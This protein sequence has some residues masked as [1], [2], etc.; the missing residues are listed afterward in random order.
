MDNLET[1][2]ANE[3]FNAIANIAYAELEAEEKGLPI[4]EKKK[5]DEAVEPATQTTE[6]SSEPSTEPG[7]Q[8]AQPDKP[9][10]EAPTEEAPVADVAPTEAEITDYAV[11]HSMTPAEA[12]ADIEATKA[13]LKNYKSPEEIARALRST[14][15]AY[16]KLKSEGTKKQ[17]QVFA[18]MS[19]EQFVQQANEHFTKEQ[20]KH[21][22]KY[23]Q[24]FPKQSELM[25]DE[26]IIENIVYR[27]L[28]EYKNWAKEKVGEVQ[29]TAEKRREEIL[30][31]IPAD[32]RKWLPGV[33]GILDATDSRTI[34]DEG[35]DVEDL[36]RHARGEKAGYQA[37]IKEAEERGY[38]RGL[39]APKILGIKGID[40]KTTVNTKTTTG[41]NSAQQARAVQMFPD[42]SPEEAH[43][44]FKEVYEEDLKTNPNFVS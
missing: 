27:A 1:A 6:E 39:E 41:L 16:D 38:K 14:Q 32:D 22:E 2:V 30:A 17:P 43:K 24:M 7:T 40:G 10:E 37:A 21:V 3:D 34:L 19:D 11:K 4:P 26:A 20:E 9:A 31:N 42:L 18:P 35:F 28:G 13:V 23:R 5:D 36:L 29:K 33:K 44:S 8:E 25:T 12:K 15:S